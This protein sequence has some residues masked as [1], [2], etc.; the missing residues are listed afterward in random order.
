M[1]F[2]KSEVGLIPENWDVVELKLKASI[3]MGQSPKSD[4]YNNEGLG[5]PFMQGRKT[6]G[7]KYHDIDTWCTDP[8]RLADKGDI[9]MSVR[10]PVGDV[11]VATTDLCIGRGLASLKMLNGNNEFLYYLLKSYVG[12]ITSRETGTVFASINKKGLETIKLPFPSDKEQRVIANILSTLDEKTKTNNKIN[13]KLEEMAQSLFKH[14]FVDFEFPNENGEPYKSSGG[15]MIKSELGMIPKDWDV[16]QLGELVDVIDNRGKTPPLSKDV[17]CYPIIDVRALSGKNR[18]VNYDNCTKFVD[19]KT[20][21]SWFRNG[22]PKEGDILLSTVGS[23]GE[24]KLFY[25]DIGC[26]AQN[27]V[28]LR[29]KNISYLY[30]YQYLQNIKNELVSYNIGSVQPSIKITHVKKHKIL[31][32]NKN[33]ERD[34]IKFID[35][36]SGLIYNNILESK[37]LTSVRDILLP[38]LMSGEIRVLLEG[39]VLESKS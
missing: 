26:I 27:V 34:F 1:S 14:W 20:Y 18:I 37:H 5:I 9:L 22:H 15:E 31:V 23:I 7:D 11:N 8:K 16:S 19:K 10:A 13:E 24:L 33:I 17:T 12:E 36:I 28:A 29:T 25:G 4:S 6:F 39:E 32:P 35:N 3:T 30:L 2:K 21:D 38:K